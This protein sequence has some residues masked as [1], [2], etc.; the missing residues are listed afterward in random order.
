MDVSLR[1]VTNAVGGLSED[2]RQELRGLDV[3]CFGPPEQRARHPLT[4]D[5]D[6]DI[7]HIV[8]VW[9]D[10]L[11]VSGLW[12]AQ[13]GILIG[14][15]PASIAG[16]RGVRTDPAFRRRGFATAAM[17]CAQDFIWRELQPD[18][19]MLHSSV[20]AVPFYQSLGWQIV[21]GPVFCDQPAG[22]LN[23]TEALPH[24]PIM[25][26]LPAGRDLPRDPIDLC[27]LPF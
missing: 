9:D 27:G 5:P 15:H 11:L 2:E 22:K 21:E 7:S 8:R 17:Q 26:L 25:V 24:N 3:R 16:I 14:G 20:M 18:L 23:V 6:T 10:G 13:R 12:I 1:P 4:I 19:A